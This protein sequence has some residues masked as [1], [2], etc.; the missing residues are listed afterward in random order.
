MWLPP[1]DCLR[2]ESSW[3]IALPHS[4]VRLIPWALCCHQD[5]N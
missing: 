5:R 4:K 2:S 3:R 1:Y